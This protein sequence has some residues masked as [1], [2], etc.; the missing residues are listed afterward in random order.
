MILCAN[1]AWYNLCTNA[2][3]SYMLY[4][5]YM[6]FEFERQKTHF[7]FPAKKVSMNACMEL[8]RLSTSNK[9]KNHWV[10]LLQSLKI[11]VDVFLEV[12]FFHS[13]YHKLGTSP[14]ILLTFAHDWRYIK[15]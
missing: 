6:Y 11:S 3:Y 8:V 1:D 9:V 5:Q 2:M 7:I 10:R 4:I 15:Y 14:H 13:R 12:S